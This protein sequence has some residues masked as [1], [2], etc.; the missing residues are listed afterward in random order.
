MTRE[1]R[2]AYAKGYAAAGR[3]A[4]PAHQPP[5][6]PE[7]VVKKLVESLQKLRD[8]A[9]SLQALFCEGDEVVLLFAPLIDEADAAMEKVTDWLGVTQ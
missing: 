1:E 6:P 8:A 3:H 9:D 5:T 4:W 2:L 7:P